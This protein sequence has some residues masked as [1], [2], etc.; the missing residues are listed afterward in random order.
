M[1]NNEPRKLLSV[2]S[3]IEAKMMIELLNNNNIACLKKDNF[4]GSYMDIFMGYSI[5]GEDIYV[6]KNDYEKAKELLDSLGNEQDIEI[7]EDSIPS[8]S[9]EIA[10]DSVL[11]F[12]KNS[13]LVA[14]ILLAIVVVGGAIMY[15]IKIR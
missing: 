3:E 8:D 11:P 5:F 13:Q 2:S 1:D 14:R 15:L 7:T 9:M 6:N 10:E 4:T 12:Y